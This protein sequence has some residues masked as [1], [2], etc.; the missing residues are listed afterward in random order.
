MKEELLKIAQESLSSDE[1]NQIVK[2]K[3]HKAL[4][5]A[6]ESAFRW[7]D[8]KDAL[9]K[10]AT[11][12]MV[13]YIE[14]Y[15][16]SAYLPK[17][18]SVLTE[19]VN[20][21]TC[22]GNKQI[23]KN[24]KDLM[25][26]PEQ[27]EI[28]VT[29]LFKAWINQCNKDIDTDDLE[30]DYD[31]GVSYSCVECEMRVEKLDKPSWSSCQRAI[32]TFENEHDEK[33]N[34]EIPISKWVWDSGKEEPYT[35]SVANDVMISSLRSLNPF[36]ILLLRLERAQTAIIIDKDYEDDYIYPEKEPEASFS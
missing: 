1:V 6:V 13:L 29:D 7:G 23:L 22:M 18:D 34:I 9:K 12:V 20:S 3:F 16:F 15:D 8:A 14:S 19:L 30:I 32:I 11:E 28:K 31:D 25:T 26:E 35:L 27:K 36:Q 17:L 21:D 24:F 4:G 10:K 2:E 5:D 33:L